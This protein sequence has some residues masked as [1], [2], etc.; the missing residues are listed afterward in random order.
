MKKLV[1]LLVLSTGLLVGCREEKPD[2]VNLSYVNAHWTV[3]KYS[4]EQPEEIE[5]VGETLQACTGKLTTELKGDLTVYDTVIANRH[6]MTDTGEEYA[7][8]AVT[9]IKG[10]E[11]YVLCRDVLSERFQAEVIDAFPHFVNT[12]KGNH[13]QRIPFI[14]PAGESAEATFLDA[15]EL[16]DPSNAVEPF[17]DTLVTF[18]PA[19]HGE[20]ELTIGDRPVQFPLVMFDPTMA[21]MDEIKFAIGYHPEEQKPYVL[22]KLADMFFSVSP[23]DEIVDPLNGERLYEE[24]TVKRLPLQSELLPDKSYPLYEFNY[25]REG[26]PVTEMVTITYRAKELLTTSEQKALKDNPDEQYMPTVSGPLIYLHEKPFN[27]ESI[28]TYPT[29]LRASGN[30]MDDLIQAID[31]AEP[32]NRSGDAGEYPYLTIVDGLKGQEFEVTYKQRSK[33]LDVYVTDRVTEET[34]K[35]T[36]EGAETFLSYFPDLKKK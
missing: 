10:D 19:V 4:L 6:P 8:K 33:K 25:T 13:I 35:L 20:M 31:G 5:A 1:G 18:T 26:K 3:S 9:Y 12:E 36:S 28:L 29:V 23:I 21:H 14:E 32:T 34:Y 7:Y 30:E 16:M 27:N 22:M 24:L 15:D 11:H 17:L 2:V